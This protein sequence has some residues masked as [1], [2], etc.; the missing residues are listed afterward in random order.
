MPKTLPAIPTDFVFS[1]GGSIEFPVGDASL[2]VESAEDRV[3][4][5]R[6]FDITRDAHGLAL[7]QSLCAILAQTIVVLQADQA[8]GTLPKVLSVIE[9]TVRKNPFEAKN[10]QIHYNLKIR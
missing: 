9:P 8:A 4:F 6:D 3:S 1:A 5:M 2:T 10:S 7:A